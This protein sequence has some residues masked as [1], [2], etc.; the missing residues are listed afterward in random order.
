MKCRFVF[1]VASVASVVVANPI[2]EAVRNFCSRRILFLCLIQCFFTTMAWGGVVAPP[3]APTNLTATAIATNKIVLTWKDMSGNEGGFKLD[4]AT[5]PNGPWS[6]NKISVKANKMVYT[7]TGLA[8]GTTFYYR[9]RS[10]N[11]KG[12]S[13]YSAVASATTFY[14]PGVCN[15]TLTPA[16][17]SIGPEAGSGSIDISAA[18]NCNWSASTASTWVTL[19]TNSGKGPATVGYSVTAN[20]TTNSRT[21]SIL[22]AGKSFVLTQLGVAPCTYACSGGGNFPAS[23][24]SGSVTVTAGSGCSW[25]ASANDSWITVLSSQSMGQGAVNFAVEANTNSSGRIGTLTVAGKQ[26]V[27]SQDGAVLTLGAAVENNSVN[28]L[29]GGNAS[30]SPQTNVFM[31]GGAAAQSGLIGN[32]QISWM[33]FYISGF[34][35]L[36]FYWKSSSENDWDYVRFYIDG[37]EQAAICGEVDWRQEYYVLSEGTHEVKWVYGKD[38]SC[39]SGG[40][41]AVW[42]DRVEIASPSCVYSLASSQA[43]FSE[44]GGIGTV[45]LATGDGCTWTASTT[46]NWIHTTSGGS[47]PG[48]V[49]YTVDPNTSPEVREGAILVAG[50]TLEVLQSGVA[51]TYALN[52]SSLSHGATAASGSFAI[53]THAACG[54][55]AFPSAGWIH[56]TSSGSGNGTISYTVDANTSAGSRSAT[57]S[58]GEQ[59]FTVNQAGAS[60][61]Y[62]L[63]PTIFNHSDAGSGSFSV[64]TS[65]VAP[66][67]LPR[68][69][70]GFTRRVPAMEMAA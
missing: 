9:I 34:S 6:I 52:P 51:C 2:V 69:R 48:T 25:T 17:A 60:C 19:S 7:N 4:R 36:S 45:N 63:S 59:T 16:N 68:L 38:P 57:I 10:Y 46:N 53:A 18:T 31:S 56:T 33:G 24:G 47:G 35:V 39:C 62:A 1:S 15:F 32:G 54:W 49:G 50:R 43:A 66:G 41:D 21:A 55:A 67:Q 28:W 26:V 12:Y 22:V 27:I 29:T 13:T 64:T 5:S 65:P 3:A 23:G 40:S 14:R 42:V 58:A 44:N 70:V 20:P 8:S 11:S 37:V 61:S 30:W